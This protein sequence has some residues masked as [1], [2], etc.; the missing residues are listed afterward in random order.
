MS[1][2]VGIDRPH[3]GYYCRTKRHD[4][5][6]PKE[7]REHPLYVRPEYSEAERT[8]GLPDDFPRP[9]ANYGSRAF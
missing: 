4:P 3:W 2:K 7:E 8:P 1:E 6:T 5:A 9:D